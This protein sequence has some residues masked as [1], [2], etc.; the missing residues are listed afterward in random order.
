MRPLIVSSSWHAGND[1]ECQL[2]GAS[3]P[4]STCG[5]YQTGNGSVIVKHVNSWQRSQ[6]LRRLLLILTA[7]CVV[8]MIAVVW[9]NPE[10]RDR[11]SDAIM[12]RTENQPSS[13]AASPVEEPAKPPAAKKA[14]NPVR[15]SLNPPDQAVD[16]TQPIAVEALPPEQPSPVP[17][18]P[19]HANVKSDSAAAYSFNS[20]R[21]PIVHMLKKGDTVQTTLELIDS[22]GRWSLIRT[23]DL[24][25]SA[26]V[27]SEDLERASADTTQP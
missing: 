4:R 13:L 22:E 5:P 16:I 10:V 15:R 7:V 14:K 9:R 21:S 24:K 18:D 8:G 25:R 11:I 27:R 6:A 2:G 20:S 26:F 17:A 19:S 12:G 1:V 3:R 23:P